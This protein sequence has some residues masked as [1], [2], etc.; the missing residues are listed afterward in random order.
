MLVLS[1]KSGEQIRIGTE[2]E[3]TILRIQGNRVEVG[4]AA[5]RSLSIRREDAISFPRE[6]SPETGVCL[7]MELEGEALVSAPACCGPASPY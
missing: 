4:I 2:I 1:R 7:R 5:P 3:V 6:Q